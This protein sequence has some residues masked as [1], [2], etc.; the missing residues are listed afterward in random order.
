LEASYL[1]IVI[2]WFISDVLGS[3]FIKPIIAL[4]KYC[5][6]GQLLITDGYLVIIATCLL[7][8]GFDLSSV[9]YLHIYA[10]CYSS[11]RWP[12]SP[13][14]LPLPLWWRRRQEEQSRARLLPSEAPVSK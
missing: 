13:N 3:Y 11:P 4:W 2:V 14:A 6:H 8:F 9:Y 10:W 5:Q 12:H 7:G 1:T